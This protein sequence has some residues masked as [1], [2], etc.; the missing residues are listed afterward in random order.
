MQTGTCLRHLF[1]TMLLFCAPSQPEILWVYFR[2][3]IC[4][5][6]ARKLGVLGILH[7][8]ESDS[9]NYSLYLLDKILGQSG[10]SLARDFPSMPAPL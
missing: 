6:L 4:D 8:S 2:L 7:P 1:T 10:K 9:F 5:D 3:H